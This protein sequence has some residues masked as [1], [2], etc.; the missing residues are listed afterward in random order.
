MGVVF[1]PMPF[2]DPEELKMSNDWMLKNPK[3]TDAQRWQFAASFEDMANGMML[4]PKLY[5]MVE[6]K[7]HFH[8]VLGILLPPNP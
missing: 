8:K 6:V 1:P 5:T 4:F 3:L 7:E 2:T